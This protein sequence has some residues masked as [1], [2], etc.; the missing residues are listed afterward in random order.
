MHWRIVVVIFICVAVLSIGI[1]HCN[2]NLL[3][4]ITKFYLGDYYIIVFYDNLSTMVTETIC[5]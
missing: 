1:R 3:Q 5:G 4:K 2:L